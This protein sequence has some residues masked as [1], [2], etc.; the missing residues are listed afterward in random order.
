VDSIAIARY[1][2]VTPAS[3][4]ALLEQAGKITPSGSN[5]FESLST[6]VHVGDI[7]IG[8]TRNRGGVESS[9]TWRAFPSSIG[10]W[11]LKIAGLFAT[12]LAVSLGAP[13]WFDVLNKF[14]VVRSTVKPEE[15]SRAEASKD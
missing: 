1:L 10:D 3:R 13:F 7:P 4:S 9:L 5:P 2:N 14:M 6:T 15:K 11:L 8:W 12:G